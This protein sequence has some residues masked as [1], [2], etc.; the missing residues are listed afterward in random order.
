MIHV[1][2]RLLEFI[3]FLLLLSFISFVLMKLAPGDAV[4]DVLGVED[5]AVNQDVIDAQREE[6]ASIALC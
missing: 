3:L 5:V 1:G 4:R 2:R 6:M